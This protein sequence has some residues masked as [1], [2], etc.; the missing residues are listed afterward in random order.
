MFSKI[1]LCSDGSDHALQA[2]RVACEI[3]TRFHSGLTLLSVFNPASVL[4]AFAMAPEAAPSE[5]IVRAIGEDLHAG[6]Q[7]STGSLPD[8]AKVA[9]R[10]QRETGH[11]VEAIIAA[12]AA[13]NADLIVLGSRGLSEWKALLMGSVSDGVLHHAACPVLIVRGAETSVAKILLACDGSAGAFLA[14]RAAGELSSKFGAPLTIVN[15]VEPLGPLANFVHDDPESVLHNACE[16]AGTRVRGMALQADCA[17]SFHQEVG[18][19]AETIVRIAT[20]GAYPLVVVG[21]RG[22]GVLKALALGSISNRIAHHAPC[23]VLVVR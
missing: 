5:E 18:H 20:E 23:S 16:I 1:L 8:A 3:A 2:A 10:F 21:S 19:P 7:K 6:I 13:V 9:Y 17:Y 4:G 11:P 14:T 12:A 15:V 22:M